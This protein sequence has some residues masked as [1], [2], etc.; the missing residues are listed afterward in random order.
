MSTFLRGSAGVVLLALAAC[1]ERSGST[2]ASGQTSASALVWQR[3]LCIG[4]PCYERRLLAD[5]AA[6][7]PLPVWPDGGFADGEGGT[8][9]PLSSACSATGTK[10]GDP[11]NLYC[12]P[13]RSACL[14]ARQVR[15]TTA[16]RVRARHR[17]ERESRTFTTSTTRSG[18]HLPTRPC[19]FG[20]RRTGTGPSRAVRRPRTSASSSRTTPRVPRSPRIGSTWTSTATSAWPSQ[21]FSS[22]AER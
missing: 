7:P 3:Y 17:A 4:A 18:S 20:W 21:P 14:P 19:T 12:G 22:R 15:G 2:D 10:C 8:C 5:G 16:S 9:P 6:D 1:G 13:E 11:T